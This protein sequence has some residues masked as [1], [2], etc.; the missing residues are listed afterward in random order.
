MVCSVLK[1]AVAEACKSRRVSYE[2]SAP[3]RHSTH[4]GPSRRPM[5]L[6]FHGICY[7]TVETHSNAKRFLRL[8]LLVCVTADSH[9]N[10]RKRSDLSQSPAPSLCTHSLEPG[11]RVARD[12]PQEF[13][14]TIGSRVEISRKGHPRN[15][16]EWPPNRRRIEQEQ[17]LDGGRAIPIEPPSK[18]P[19]YMSLTRCVT[20]FGSARKSLTPKPTA[21]L[22]ERHL[23]L[24]CEGEYPPPIAERM[25]IFPTDIRCQ[26]RANKF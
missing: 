14:F 25:G 3:T 11:L 4:L 26:S 7:A 22:G 1:V 23:Q 5:F 20:A 8:N 12:Q 16:R 10:Q 6:Y 19:G 24:T 18:P 9:L 13:H 17:F 21:S 2:C 15:C